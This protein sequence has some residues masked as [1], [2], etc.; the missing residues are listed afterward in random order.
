[1]S[2]DP[3]LRIKDD[4]DLDLLPVFIEEGHDLLPMVGQLLR[5]WKQQPEEIAVPQS[6][7][8]LMHTIKGSARMAGAMELGQHT[9]DMETRLE[10]LMHAGAGGVARLSLMDDLLMRHDYSMQLFDRL[11]NPNAVEVQAPA[12]PLT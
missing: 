2:S 4:L 3:D 11:Q 5:T 1:L 7:L 9:H 6:I 10:N 8:R 12:A